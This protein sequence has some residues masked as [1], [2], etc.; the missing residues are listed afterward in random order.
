M[1]KNG[2]PWSY[3]SLTSFETCPK[4]YYHTRV[5]KD[6]PDP[7]GEQAVWGQ[8]VHKHLEDRVRDGAP[9]P[10]SL[11]AYES[12]ITPI[13]QAGGTKIVEQQLAV[14]Y[15]LTPTEWDSPD[16][17][18]RGII[19][20]GVVSKNGTKATLLDW[21]TGRRKADS[22]QLMLFA[23]LAF[24]HYKELKTVVTGFIWLK[25]QK[26]DKAEFTRDQVPMIWQKFIPRVQRMELAYEKAKFPPKPSG[27]CER[28]C[29]V[30]HHQCMYSGRKRN[31]D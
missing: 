12:Y 1:K 17:W 28:Y 9:L 18:S 23:G 3:S 5:A 27:L 31:D 11:V 6:T 7:P 15:G 16:A 19:D 10:E 22:D 20:L 30:P 29:P 14:A 4:R 25:D 26:I 24:S 2:I 13:E 8:V 21:K